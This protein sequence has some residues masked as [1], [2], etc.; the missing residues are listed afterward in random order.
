M[1]PF[2]LLLLKDK[3]MKSLKERLAKRDEK[4]FTLIELVIVVAIIGILIAIAIPS[5]GAI[6]HTAR[7]NAV[8]LAASKSYAAG[9]ISIA[10]NRPLLNTAGQIIPDC[11]SGVVTEP[12][13]GED[14]VIVVAQPNKDT[15][16][17][18]A[19]WIYADGTESTDTDTVRPN[20]QNN[21]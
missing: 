8:E 10:E 12:A 4:G 20:D 14:G 7:V 6:Q 13:F 1:K 15:L 11:H 16:F 19:R 21:C 18:Y 5:Y 2:H 17:L 3:A 9:L